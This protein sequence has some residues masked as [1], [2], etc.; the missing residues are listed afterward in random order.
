MAVGTTWDSMMLSVTRGREIK[1]RTPFKLR[2][3]MERHWILDT[4]YLSEF[5]H[6]LQVVVRIERQSFSP[7]GM[8]T[9]I[10]SGILSKRAN[11]LKKQS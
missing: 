10:V 2:H 1:I 11:D 9:C 3:P 6:G 4:T 7:S 5:R 8:I